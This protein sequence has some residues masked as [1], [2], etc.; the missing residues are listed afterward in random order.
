MIKAEPC[1]L[2]DHFALVMIQNTK[3]RDAVE[4]T[5]AEAKKLLKRLPRAIEKTEALAKERGLR[6][7]TDTW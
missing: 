6:R 3:D 2:N 7:T 4:M 5:I 1:I